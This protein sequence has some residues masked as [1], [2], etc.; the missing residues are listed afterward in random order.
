[1]NI[2]MWLVMIIAFRDVFVGR[3]TLYFY[4]KVCPN[5]LIISIVAHLFLLHKGKRKMKKTP[6]FVTGIF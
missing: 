4:E 1:M 5:Y 2:T 6:I 3:I